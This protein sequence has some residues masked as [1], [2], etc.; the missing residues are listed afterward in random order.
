MRKQIPEL[1]PLEFKL[2]RT[3]WRISPA[4]AKEVQE[5]YNRRSGKDLKYT[6]V[7]TLLTRLAEKDVLKVDR[8]RQPFKFVPAVSREQMLRQRVHEFVDLF[9]DGQPVDLA[10]RLVEETDLSEESLRRLEETLERHK[11]FPKPREHG[12]ELN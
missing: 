7:M 2:L 5:E 9:F 4:S 3:L 8:E 10:V 11:S 6:T 12:E 1:G